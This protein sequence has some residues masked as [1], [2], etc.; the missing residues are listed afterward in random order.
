VDLDKVAIDAVPIPTADELDVAVGLVVAAADER[1]VAQA[2][3]VP[4]DERPRRVV[5]DREEDEVSLTDDVSDVVGAHVLGDRLDRQTSPAEHLGQGL[6][7]VRAQGGSHEVRVPPRR[8]PFDRDPG[9]DEGP[10][11]LRAC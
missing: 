10:R 6:G 3:D 8:T 4:V 5:V 2:G 9:R 7:L 1:H 11:R